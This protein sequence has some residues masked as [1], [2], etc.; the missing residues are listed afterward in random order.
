MNCVVKWTLLPACARWWRSRGGLFFLSLVTIICSLGAPADLRAQEDY[1]D[2]P[3]V[4]PT[5]L[6]VN[7]AR[8]KIV[9]GIFLGTAITADNG[10]QPDSNAALDSGDD[11]VTFP[12]PLVRGNSNLVRVVASVNGRL[13]AWID[14]DGNGNWGDPG[15]QVFHSVLLSPGT[16]DLNLVIPATSISRPYARFRFSTTGDLSPFGLA[17]DGEVEDY[18]LTILA[19]AADLAIT[20]VIS[21]N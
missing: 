21:P 11:G 20:A 14:F 13:D 16:N 1:G 12:A 19:A 18:R 3:A 9:P 6:S 5:L 2:A 4:Y 7:G 10:G 17:R 15:E 8:H